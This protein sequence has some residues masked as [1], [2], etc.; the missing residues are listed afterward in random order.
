MRSIGL[1]SFCATTVI[2]AT[3]AAAP[4]QDSMP[5]LVRI[6]LTPADLGKA[7]RL[8]NEIADAVQ[9]DP[10][11]ADSLPRGAIARSTLDDIA[12]RVEHSRL[13]PIFHDAGMTPRQ[14]IDTM[15]SV[16]GARA[17]AVRRPMGR[18]PFD[19]IAAANLQL[20]ERNADAAQ[21]LQRAV[22]RV[23]ALEGRQ[24]R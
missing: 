9:K 18:V 1:A 23:R 5:H 2:A 24:R 11:M 10:S 12:S 15:L 14:Y 20:L 22:D 4:R 16:E 3:L 7:T 8:T 21:G 6:V 13:A 19:A 17:Y